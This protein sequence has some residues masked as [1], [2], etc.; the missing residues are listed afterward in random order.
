M[1]V[2][3]LVTTPFGLPQT[4]MHLDAGTV[5]LGAVCAVLAPFLPWTCELYALRRL[6]KTAFGTLLALEPGI[7]VVIGGAVVLHQTPDVLLAFGVGLVVIAGIAAEHTGHPPA[8]ANLDPRPT[9]P[10]TPLP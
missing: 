1:P 8:H 10:A 4:I 3:A 5:A 2:A 9:H 6:S 7:A